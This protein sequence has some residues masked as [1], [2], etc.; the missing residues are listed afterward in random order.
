MKKKRIVKL[1]LISAIAVLP[2]QLMGQGIRRTDIKVEWVEPVAGTIFQ[3]PTTI[4]LKFRMYN[5]GPDTL[6]PTDT[7]KYRLS[8]DADRD[9]YKAGLRS[10][11][12]MLLPGDSMDLVDSLYV[13]VKETKT[14]FWIGFR[15]RVY[16]LGPEGA[17]Y[18][19]LLSESAS[20]D[21]DSY[22][23][24]YIHV[25]G[26]VS[27]ATVDAQRV[28]VFPNP[29]HGLAF[30]YGETSVISGIGQ[31]RIFDSQGR[32]LT[33][34]DLNTKDPRKTINLS[35]LSPGVYHLH[36]VTNTGVIPKRIV[37]Q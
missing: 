20:T 34:H 23:S 4:K 2:T 24:L 29:S 26:S 36:L 28:K 12:R 25:K 30:I 3:S 35:D 16:T 31:A 9:N 17:T 6:Y 5:V 27:V 8:H 11:G 13:D 14:K 7:V 22:P 19:L 33:V 37:L 15:R 21:T 1:L 10:M 32:L 18:G